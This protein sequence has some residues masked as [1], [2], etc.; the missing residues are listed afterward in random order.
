MVITRYSD[1]VPCIMISIRSLIPGSQLIIVDVCPILPAIITSI[2]SRTVDERKRV[3]KIFTKPI[4]SSARDRP[5]TD[6]GWLSFKLLSKAHAICYTLSDYILLRY[7]R[8]T[9]FEI[10]DLPNYSTRFTFIVL[11]CSIHP[12]CSLCFYEIQ[13]WPLLRQPPTK[14]RSRSEN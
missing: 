12:S 11:W 6:D 7:C 5:S 3:F 10:L 4:H 9:S 14:R 1:T 2:M 13:Y 8:R